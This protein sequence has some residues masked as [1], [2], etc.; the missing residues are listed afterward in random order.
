MQILPVPREM[1]GAMWPHAAPHLFTGLSVALDTP[2]QQL[3]DA[4]VAGE[5]RLW[6]I[7]EGGRVAGAF[8][9]STFI[10]EKTGK[11]FTGVYALGGEGLARWGRLLGEVMLEYAR[12]TGTHSVRFNG[13]EA[14]SRVLPAYQITGRRPGGEATFER[15]VA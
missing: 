5:D 12:T 7:I 2:L 15:T 6:V 14:W 4:L 10:D 11:T 8:V 3:A 13:R 1:I 9:T